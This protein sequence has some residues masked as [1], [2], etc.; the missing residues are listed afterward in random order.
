MRAMDLVSAEVLWR[1]AVVV[2]MLA[3]GTGSA[4]AT[5]VTSYHTVFADSNGNLVSGTITATFDLWLRPFDRGVNQSPTL[6]TQ[7][8]L[9]PGSDFTVAIPRAVIDTHQSWVMPIPLGADPHLGSSSIYA[10]PGLP[11]IDT[12]RW[13]HSCVDL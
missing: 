10:M 13:Q 11:F 3:L 2:T 5:P 6:L 4:G 9:G 1:G 12:G 8:S 7:L